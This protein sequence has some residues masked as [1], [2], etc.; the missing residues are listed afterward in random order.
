[1]Y[2]DIARTLDSWQLLTAEIKPL[3]AAARTVAKTCDARAF[4]CLA[5]R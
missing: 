2:F 4:R 5:Q 1:M 3:K